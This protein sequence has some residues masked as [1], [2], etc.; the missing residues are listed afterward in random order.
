MLSLAAKKPLNRVGARLTWNNEVPRV[1]AVSYD[2]SSLHR[3]RKWSL[4]VQRRAMSV[5]AMDGGRCQLAENERI[6]IGAVPHVVVVVRFGKMWRRAVRGD[7]GVATVLVWWGGLLDSWSL[8]WDDSWTFSEIMPAVIPARA[9][10]T[11]TV[12]HLGVTEGVGAVVEAAD[13]GAGALTTS[14]GS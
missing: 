8:H 2:H 3:G 4:A 12:C 1:I 14:P 10:R 9:R 7:R 5:M 6:S 11:V 13:H